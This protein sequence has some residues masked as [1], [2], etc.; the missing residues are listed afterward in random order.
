MTSTT[1]I[2][3]KKDR[4]PVPL[5]SKEKGPEPDVKVAARKE[6]FEDKKPEPLKREE[7]KPSPKREIPPLKK[8]PPKKEKKDEPR[9]DSLMPVKKESPKKETAFKKD[10]SLKKE[11]VSKKE[12]SAKKEAPKREDLTAFKRDAGTIK[13][14]QSKKDEPKKEQS[15]KEE[16]RKEVAAKKDS[17]KK[18][19]P[20]KEEAKKIKSPIA[21]PPERPKKAG[22]PLTESA[23]EGTIVPS[24]TTASHAIMSEIIKKTELP[25]AK[26][27]TLKRGGTP[28]DELSA[29]LL[30]QIVKDDKEFAL[31]G[32]LS[33][34]F[35]R[36]RAS[37][38]CLEHPTYLDEKFDK[39]TRLNEIIVRG[40]WNTFTDPSWLLFEFVSHSIS[41]GQ[42]TKV[43]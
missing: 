4:A 7:K 31:K 15:K 33:R 17:P 13:K 30:E 38:A 23:A 22:V 26:V 6:S 8:E 19:A 18:E 2:E 40:L 21:T 34:I 14:E 9:K 41:L 39:A 35:V 1:K 10:D 16:L 29:E 25:Q 11:P 12:E 3:A 37:H 32:T 20:K 36:F 42:E 5:S 24:M 27:P 28:V 43:I